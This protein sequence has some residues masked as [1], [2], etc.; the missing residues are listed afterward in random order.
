[1]REAPREAD[2]LS[3]QLLLRGAFIRPVA[4]GA[5]AYLPLGLRVL[6]KV[7]NIVREEMNRAGAQELHLTVL[8]P[9][10][11]W[12]ASGRWDTFRPPLYK[13]KDRVGRD[14]CLG[15]THEECF[16]DIA[17]QGI[18]S[19][20]D[21]PVTLY[22]IQVK[23]RD[24]LRPRGGLIRCKEFLMKDAY[25]FDA[26][27]E[28]L[29][30]S[31]EAMYEAYCRIFTRCGLEYEV[32]EAS[33][34]SMGGYGT[35]EFMLMAESG[36]DTVLVCNACGYAANA[37]F[38]PCLSPGGQ[39]SP[40]AASRRERVDTPGKTTIEEVTEFLG[41]PAERLVKTLL[42]RSHDRQFIAALVRGDRDLN[43][44]KLAQA[45]QVAA[46]E[47]ATADEIEHLTGAPV[48]F[49]G[50]VGLPDSVRVIADLEIRAM[51]DFVVGANEADAHLVNVNVGVDFQPCEYA[52]LRVAVPGDR[53]PSCK[54][55]R[56]QARRGIELGHIFKLGT[57]YSE[58]MGVFFVD[59]NNERRPVIMGC[60]GIGVSRIVAAIVEA[61][62]DDDGII[63]PMS[64]APFHVVILLLDDSP[65]LVE[66]AH[67][68]SAD[69][70]ARGTEVLLDERDESPGVK[71]KDAD[72]IGI[73]LKAVVGRRTKQQGEIEIQVRSDGAREMVPAEQA[74]DRI[75]QLVAEGLAATGVIE[76]Q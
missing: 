65:E 48:G 25:S 60:Y 41:V 29:D 52:D 11:L 9:A 53:C 22:Q 43:E 71:F 39:V 3:H 30:R 76:P 28:G 1:M 14:F 75:R 59:E 19:H 21:M 38:A 44:D 51:A 20:K 66:I 17:K 32:V 5:F 69:L 2:V 36:E 34:G 73:P 70:E 31:F 74:A 23:F 24:E 72:L 40:P 45:A 50:P 6:R 47:M 33:G 68:L 54:D 55:G 37:E 64:V 62:H 56:F 4:A 61:S 42:Y 12:I 26:S 16:A 35:R 8:Q 63:W 15:P 18:R 7:E 13:L 49:S 58:D 27:R 46:L 57:K 10:E 67:D